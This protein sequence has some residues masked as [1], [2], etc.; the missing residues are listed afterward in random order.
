MFGGSGSSIT[1][2]DSMVVRDN[3]TKNAVLASNNKGNRSITG[4]S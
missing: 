1:G 2:A 4:V 3:L